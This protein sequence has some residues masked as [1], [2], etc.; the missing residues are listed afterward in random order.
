MWF[1][2][3]STSNGY[4]S[5]LPRRFCDILAK[6]SKCCIQNRL[7]APFVA[8][9]FEWR[10]ILKTYA[11]ISPDKQNNNLKVSDCLSLTCSLFVWLTAIKQFIY[12]KWPLNILNYVFH[13]H[14]L[15]SS[16]IKPYWFFLFIVNGDRQIFLAKKRTWFERLRFLLQSFLKL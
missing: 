10:W 13:S 1:V 14:L 7:G 8:Y 4:S 16:R 5:V 2:Y 12:L 9:E 15:M 3:P 11:V 6:K